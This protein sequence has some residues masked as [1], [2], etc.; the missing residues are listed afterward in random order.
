MSELDPH[1]VATKSIGNLA[2]AIGV[3]VDPVLVAQ[4]AGLVVGL[5][6]GKKWEQAERAGLARAAAI[7]D[8]ESADAAGRKRG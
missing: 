5:L 2:E 8:L 6:T 4:V 3:D 1:D 7:K